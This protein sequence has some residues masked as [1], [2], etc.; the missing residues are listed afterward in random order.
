MSTRTRLLGLITLLCSGFAYAEAPVVEV[1]KSP[2]CGCCTRWEA[3][4]EENG[5]EVISHPTENMSAVKQR[6]GVP[7]QMASCHTGIINGY[8]IEGHVPV[9]DIRRLLEEQPEVQGLA[10]PGMPAGQNVPGMETRPGNAQ[11]DVWA[12]RSQEAKVFSR[13]E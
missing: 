4:L 11:F 5:F 1:F 6:L 9:S 8:F 2:H 3:I 10:V 13:Q 7:P 12:V